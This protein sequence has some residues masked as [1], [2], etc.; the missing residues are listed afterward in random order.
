MAFN[1]SETERYKQALKCVKEFTGQRGNPAIQWI[2]DLIWECGDDPNIAKKVLPRRL[3]TRAVRI[4]YNSLSNIEKNNFAVL[5][6]QFLTQYVPSSFYCELSKYLQAR[7]QREGESVQSY[8]DAFD[9]VRSKMGNRCPSDS[10]LCSYFRSGLDSAIRSR[11][12]VH[13][14][15][16]SFEDIGMI[17]E[18]ARIIEG[19]NLNSIRGVSSS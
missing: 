2:A 11:L 15:H 16:D 10:V 8:Y 12:P 4:W 7:R 18:S 17:L 13:Q 19:D 1:L 14:C 5:K 9:E 3:G 6:A